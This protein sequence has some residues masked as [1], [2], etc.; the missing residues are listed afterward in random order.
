MEKYF[1]KGVSFLSS[2]FWRI[3]QRRT[4]LLFSTPKSTT[5]LLLK[6]QSL[7]SK[8]YYTGIGLIFSSVWLSYEIFKNKV[9][10]EKTQC[11]T[12]CEQLQ[13]QDASKLTK[14]DAKIL[15]EQAK[16]LDAEGMNVKALELYKIALRVYRKATKASNKKLTFLK[17]RIAILTSFQGKHKSAVCSQRE[18]FQ[19]IVSKDLTE[20]I[21]FELYYDLCLYYYRFNELFSSIQMFESCLKLAQFFHNEEIEMLTGIHQFLGFCYHRKGKTNLGDEHLTIALKNLNQLKS[22]NKAF[23]YYACYEFSEFYSTIGDY[24][25]ALLFLEEAKIV[26]NQDDFFSAENIQKGMNIH[27]PYTQKFIQDL[28]LEAQN[29]DLDIKARMLRCKLGEYNQNNTKRNVPISK[30]SKHDKDT[31]VHGLLH[32]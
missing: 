5:G 7:F 8:P 9:I 19:D 27:S 2:N 4:N 16:Q 26:L 17:Q 12:E 14:K 29:E 6:N 22:T 30:L 28:R 15:I 32:W 31:H 11:L 20:E 13:E 23:L 21:H 1:R 25:K 10:E 18:S 24:K 3:T